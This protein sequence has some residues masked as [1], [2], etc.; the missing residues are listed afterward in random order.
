MVSM[1]SEERLEGR[2]YKK[3]RSWQ[4]SDDAAAFWACLLYFVFK[5]VG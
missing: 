3:G 4:L 5:P 1:C 2:A